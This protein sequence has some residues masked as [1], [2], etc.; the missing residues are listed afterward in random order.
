[1]RFHALPRAQTRTVSSGCPRWVCRCKNN[2]RS[3]LVDARNS[4]H[5]GTCVGNLSPAMGARNEEGMGLS[6]NGRPAY[7]AWLLNSRLG[8]WNRFLAPQ[9]DVFFR[10][11]RTINLSFLYKLLRNRIVGGYSSPPHTRGLQFY[12]FFGI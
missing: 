10:R 11:W 9:R 5:G 12:T 1:V 3:S 6:Y 8:S 4:K 2:R 7:V